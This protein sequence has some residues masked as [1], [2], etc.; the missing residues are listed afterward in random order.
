MAST[1]KITK[2][3]LNEI[4]NLLTDTNTPEL[5]GKIL[6]IGLNT[7]ME[8]ERDEHVGVDSYERSNERTGYRNG[9]KPRQLYTRVGALN[10]LVPQTRDG[11]FYPSVLERYQRSEKALVIALAEAYIQGVS[12]RKMK[13]VTEELLGKEFSSATISRYASKLDAELDAWRTRTFNVSFP[14]V[15]VDARY[16][17]CRVGSKIIDIAVLTAI[18][19]DQYGHRHFLA[20]E[21]AWGETNTS[22]DN[23]FAGLKERGLDG[24]RLFTSD[25]HPGIRNA[26]K[27]NFPG[28]QW[29]RCQRHF[30]VNA[31]D[32]VPR[33]DRDRVHDELVEVWASHTYDQALQRLNA[34]A[35]DWSDPFEGFA[36]FLSE[37]GL[38]TLTVFSAVPKEH[39]KK[40]RTSNMVERTNQEFKRRGRVVR[41]FPNPESCIRL[42]GSLAKEWDEDWISGRKYMNMESLW[43][44][45]KEFASK[46]EEL[47]P[48]PSKTPQEIK[49]LTVA[50]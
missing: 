16:D 23:F 17:K 41:I 36:Q 9:Y 26:I 38:E 46:A 14:Y 10:L 3:S 21:S 35:T 12:T 33:R 40:L 49:R 43:E 29:Q 19:V 6:E 32:K 37:E 50:L 44:W 4:Q 45:E 15:I 27:K 25:H 18:G 7:L 1:T 42:Y 20:I 30:L 13:K 39:H 34:M 24:V 11:D 22:W 2:D 8:M 5:L 28:T 31:M 48:Q 47:A